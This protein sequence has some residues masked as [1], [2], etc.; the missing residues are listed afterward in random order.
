M[1]AWS[2]SVIGLARQPGNGKD[3]HLEIPAPADMRTD[4]MAVPE[5]TP[6]VL[7]IRVDAASD[8]IYVSGDVRA[9]VEG[10]CVRCLD[11]IVRDENFEVSELYL[12]PEAAARALEDGDEEA[13]DMLRTDGDTVDLEPLVRDTLVAEMPFKPLC[14]EDCEGLCPGCGIR[15]ADAE[16]GHEHVVID[17]R[18]A[19]L[20]GL[21]EQ[22]PEA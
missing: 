4:V 13:Q 10:E 7:D 14:R 3:V 2:I 5:G 12:F 21:L 11:P 20:Q 22:E 19:A 18:F 16:P 6:I 8:G 1:S 17:P 9:R 15:M